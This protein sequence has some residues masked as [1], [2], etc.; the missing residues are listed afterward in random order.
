[1]RAGWGALYFVD[2]FSGVAYGVC[3]GGAGLLV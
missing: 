1:M 3:V 2:E